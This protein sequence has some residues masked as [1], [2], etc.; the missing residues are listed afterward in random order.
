[1]AGTQCLLNCW[2]VEDSGACAVWGHYRRFSGWFS[3]RKVRHVWLH[4]PQSSFYSGKF[5]FW[6]FSFLPQCFRM[7]LYLAGLSIKCQKTKFALVSFPAN[8]MY[9]R[10]RLYLTVTDIKNSCTFEAKKRLD[11]LQELS[12]HWYKLWSVQVLHLLSV[13]SYSI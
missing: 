12:I 5:D 1:M 6:T 4:A 9:G 7:I 3:T 13:S 2:L 11:T 8:V 10:N